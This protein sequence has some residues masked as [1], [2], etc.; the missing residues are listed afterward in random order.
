MVIDISFGTQKKVIEEVV[1]K[2]EEKIQKKGKNSFNSMWEI[3][4][5]MTEEFDE[6]KTELHNKDPKKFREELRD[7]LIVALW[8]MMS[9]DEWDNEQQLYRK[10]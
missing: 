8:G 10:N 2:F 7:M 1:D 6:V 5:K 3:V 9:M 4:G